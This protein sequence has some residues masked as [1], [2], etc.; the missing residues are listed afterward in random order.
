MS[1]LVTL[2]RT[3]PV[4]LAFIGAVA[5]QT[6][7]R[8]QAAPE[9][10]AA[11]A[12]FAPDGTSGTVTVEAAG[13]SLEVTD[14]LGK[15]TRLTEPLRYPMPELFVGKRRSECEAYFNERSDLIA[16][17]VNG[18]LVGGPLQIAVANLK[19][20]DWLGEW[21]IEPQ[22]GLLSPNLAGFL[23]GTTS[24]VVEGEP[25][26]ENG[27]GTQHGVLAILLFDPTGK[28]L[29]P[30]LPTRSYSG[31]TD[32]IPRYADA[33][34]NRLWFCRCVAVSRTFSRQPLGPVG[35]VTLVGDEQRPPEFTPS[36]QGKKRTDLWLLPTSFAAPD[37]DTVLMAEGNRLWRVDMR[38]QSIDSLVLPMRAHFPSLDAFARAAAISPDGQVAA[39]ALNLDALAFPY[40]VDGY[41]YKG[42]DIAVVHVRPL[43]LLKIVRDDGAP[44]PVGIAVDHRQGRVTI[45]FYRKDHWERREVTN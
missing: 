20:F 25:S 10:L 24:L 43:K 8:S 42:T 3:V 33:S 27:S 36:I 23:E 34:H 22:S 38:G 1:D 13:L 44:N 41:V 29:M 17:G 35:S 26:A 31:Q 40:L 6:N 2:L 39:V 14:S 30:R 21:G 45:L 5:V 11:C 32:L 37:P 12:A 9:I 28:E 16:I 19:A 18:G 4:L 7:I 15:V